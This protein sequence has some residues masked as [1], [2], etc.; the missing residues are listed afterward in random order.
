VDTLFAMHGE[1]AMHGRIISSTLIVDWYMDR[2]GMM[3]G[4]DGHRLQWH[5]QSKYVARC[6][7]C[8]TEV[9]F[10]CEDPVYPVFVQFF[11]V[12]FTVSFRA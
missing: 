10:E 2:D 5:W 8:F 3:G 4:E 12:S 7:P 1:L 9:S 6:T 11:R